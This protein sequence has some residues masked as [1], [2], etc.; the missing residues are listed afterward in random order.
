[1]DGAKQTFGAHAKKVKARKE[2]NKDIAALNEDNEKA[3]AGKAVIGA[4]TSGN[5]KQRQVNGEKRDQ[6]ITLNE[7]ART[8]RMKAMEAS[9]EQKAHLEKAKKNEELAN[10]TNNEKAKAE[11][12]KIAEQERKLAEQAGKKKTALMNEAKSKLSQSQ[13][14]NEFDEVEVPSSGTTESVTASISG[15]SSSGIKDYNQKMRKLQ[16][17]YDKKIGD[18]N[19]EKRE[20]IRNMTKGVL[21]SGGAVFGATAGAII[22]GADGDLQA[23]ARG[24]VSGAGLA[25]KAV[26]FTTDLSFDVAEFAAEKTKNAAGLVKEFAENTAAAYKEQSSQIDSDTE[27]AMQDVSRAAARAYS[28]SSS[29]RGSK[30]KNVAKAAWKGLGRTTASHSLTYL[31]GRTEAIKKELDLKAHPNTSN[32]DEKM[33]S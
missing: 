3:G 33:D 20:G 15:S 30:A 16:S 6:K 23:A 32:Y 17:E 28:K 10:S 11:L 8:A 26:S 22:G 14:I 19:K 4:S 21:E 31:S 13:A 7:Q 25:D 1:M 5:T 12:N 29:G 18:I 27:K 9:K 2:L 24:A